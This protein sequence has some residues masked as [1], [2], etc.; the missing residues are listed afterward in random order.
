LEY[1]ISVLSIL[2]KID[3]LFGTLF[4]FYFIHSLF[5]F[6]FPNKLLLLSDI[7]YTCAKASEFA[8]TKGIIIADTKFE[9]GLTDQG[10]LVLIDEV[11]TPG[12]YFFLFSF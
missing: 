1:F 7:I 5:G 12:I 3:G 6:P 8:I 9:F 4:C 11:L 10:E 2:K